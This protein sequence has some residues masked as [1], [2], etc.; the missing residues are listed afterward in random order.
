MK[1]FLMLICACALA[2]SMALAQAAASSSTTT[3]ST[4]TTTTKTHKKHAAAKKHMAKK[5]GKKGSKSTGTTAPA[6]QQ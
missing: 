5:S 6:P 2:G 1:K 4:S 3:T